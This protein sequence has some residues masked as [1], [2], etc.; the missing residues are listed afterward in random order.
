M[1]TCMEDT[2]F[3]ICHA[4]YINSAAHTR[5]YRTHTT[6]RS[7]PM[8]HALTVATAISKQSQALFLEN[9]SL[10]KVRLPT[11]EFG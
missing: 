7:S 11:N 3:W 5:Q 2:K 6:T 4:Q 10:A 8:A 1:E 9:G